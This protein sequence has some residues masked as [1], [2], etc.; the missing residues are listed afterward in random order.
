MARKYDPNKTYRPH[1]EYCPRCVTAKE[2][3]YHGF[4]PTYFFESTTTHKCRHCGSTMRCLNIDGYE[5]NVIMRATDWNVS[6][7]ERMAAL[8]ETD[9][10]TFKKQLNKWLSH[11]D[12]DYFFKY[13]LSHVARCDWCIKLDWING[14]IFYKDGRC[15][16][17]Y[18]LTPL[19][20]VKKCKYCGREL[21][22]L[23]VSQGEID[24]I[25]KLAPHGMS[26]LNE[27]LKLRD[28]DINKY[29]WKLGKMQTRRLGIRTPR[30]LLINR[31]LGSLYIISMLAFLIVLIALN[32]AD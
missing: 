12:V 8:K 31:I 18:A 3:S 29:Y 26:F 6:E 1:T 24:E 22:I 17:H 27:M 15:F 32:L 20:P 11:P 19:R 28:E 16:P 5:K 9:P 14:V 10:T 7:L 21:S 4:F 13:G 2:N 30:E 23:D 25:A